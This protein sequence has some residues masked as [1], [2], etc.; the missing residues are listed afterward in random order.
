MDRHLKIMV[1][2]GKKQTISVIRAEAGRATTDIRSASDVRVF[3]G[4]IGQSIKRIGDTLGRQS[5][6]IHIFAKEARGT[7]FKD[8]LSILNSDRT[9]S[10]RW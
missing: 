2:R 10:S 6:V 8:T 3:A 1:V 9:S 4:E 7:S 5:R